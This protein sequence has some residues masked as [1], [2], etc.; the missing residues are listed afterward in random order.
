[1]FCRE[2]GRAAGGG[3]CRTAGENMEEGRG[4][5]GAA[6]GLPHEFAEDC[7]LL[8]VKALLIDV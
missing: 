7:L 1:M 4:K 3:T 8:P 5:R 6:W 2:A